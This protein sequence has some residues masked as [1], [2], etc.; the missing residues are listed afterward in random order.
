ML[1]IYSK[2]DDKKK[3]H[4]ISENDIN[5]REKFKDY[6]REAM[7]KEANNCISDFRISYGYDCA[8]ILPIKIE[9]DITYIYKDYSIKEKK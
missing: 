8:D 6:M 1:I 5:I 2:I 3:K 9:H 4:V 7:I